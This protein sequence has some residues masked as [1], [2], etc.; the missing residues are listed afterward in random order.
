VKP[1]V[2]ALAALSLAGGAPA[3]DSPKPN[4][5]FTGPDGIVLMRGVKTRLLLRGRRSR[6]GRRTATAWHT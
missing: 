6:P 4:V 3:A 1:A 5:A 2:L